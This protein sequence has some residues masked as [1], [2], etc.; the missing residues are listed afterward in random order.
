MKIKM[1][2]GVLLLPFLLIFKGCLYP[3][4]SLGNSPIELPEYFGI[5]HTWSGPYPAQEKYAVVDL[6]T[7]K[8]VGYFNASY[9]WK[10]K[11]ECEE[12]WGY[13]IGKD[14]NCYFAIRY[15]YMY[16]ALPG[17]VI[18]VINPGTG[19]IVKEIEVD[20]GPAYFY[21]FPTQ[22]VPSRYIY[23]MRAYLGPNVASIIDTKECKLVKEIEYPGTN[24]ILKSDSGVWVVIANKIYRW[25]MEKM[26][27]CPNPI[28]FHDIGPDQ[29]YSAI[30]NNKIYF[31]TND[32]LKVY[33]MKGE[34]LH[35]IG[36][37]KYVKGSRI[38]KGKLWVVTGTTEGT[39]VYIIDSKEDRVITKIPVEDWGVT[40]IALEW[41]YSPSLNR[42][43]I[44]NTVLDAE[45]YEVVGN[46]EHPVAAVNR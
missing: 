19:E 20:I 13:T 34:Y 11:D 44:Q 38:I 42:V 43:F 1:W 45:T 24:G 32:G 12:I 23:V 6:E 39:Y 14:G 40:R 29:Y 26:D 22:E 35:S 16:L 18:R 5:G 8:V 25:N 2:G 28:V 41:A 4:P 33:N 15:R 21:P 9:V 27:T 31:S 46:I 3:E 30:V 7:G 17:N 10:D 37:S 36:L